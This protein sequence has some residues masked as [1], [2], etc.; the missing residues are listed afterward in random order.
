VDPLAGWARAAADGDQLA[1]AHLVRAT[2]PEVLRLCAHLVDR[3][4]AE[5]LAQET[6]LRALRSLPGFRGEAPFRLW[7]LSIARRTCAD[8]LRTT[9]RRRRLAQRLLSAPREQ[10]PAAVGGVAEDELLAG[11]HPD[12]RAA[13]VLTQL[14]GLSYEEAAAAC[15]VPVG[16][17]RSRVARARADLLAA[18]RATETG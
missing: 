13:F 11:L 9:V 17:I 5:D 12:R 7:L 16:T 3:E 15:E 18:H 14:L 8:H 6:Y 4:A 2:Q 1:V 10:V